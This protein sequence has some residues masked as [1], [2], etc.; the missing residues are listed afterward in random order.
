MSE[1]YEAGIK[2]GH[3]VLAANHALKITRAA[4]VGIRIEV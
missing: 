4:Y 1:A 2:T 3:E